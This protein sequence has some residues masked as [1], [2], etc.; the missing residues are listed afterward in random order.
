M[1]R[2]ATMMLLAALALGAR[3]L[4]AS[5]HAF[6]QNIPAAPLRGGNNLFS[7][8]LLL[9]DQVDNAGVLGQVRFKSSDKLDWGLQLGFSDAG[10]GAVLIGGDLRPLLSSSSHDSPLDV[11]ADI[12]LGL[13]IGDNYTII[14]VVPGLEVSH[15]F[16]LSGSS[17]ALSPY[18][19][20]GL[21]INHVSV[22]NGGSDTNLDVVA[23]F[24]LEWE[25]APKIGV[26][27]EFGVGNHQDNFNLGA[28][29]PF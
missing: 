24:G 15:R 20:I 16:P 11:A 1:R 28:N 27:A 26:I 5:A 29:V 9:G 10:S 25:A 18:G 6:G 2:L 3:A 17:Q 7:I 13:T 23:R 19:G 12:P 14:Q 21:D 4:P 22:D 8:D